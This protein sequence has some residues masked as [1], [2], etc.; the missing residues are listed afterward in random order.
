LTSG[1]EDPNVIDPS[2]YQRLLEDLDVDITGVC[3]RLASSLTTGNAIYYFMETWSKENVPH[4]SRRMD[5]WHEKIKVQSLLPT[6][7]TS[8][9]DTLSKMKDILL[10][11][12]KYASESCAEETFAE[13]YHWAFT[14]L[15][16]N[17]MQKVVDLDVLYLSLQRDLIL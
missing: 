7:L 10:S 3:Y 1:S 12:E 5:S 13:I 8:R 17:E 2:G 15:K 11:L 4:Y 16:E 6:V 9:V 14:Y